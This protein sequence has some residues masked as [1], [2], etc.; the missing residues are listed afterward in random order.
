MAGSDRQWSFRDAEE[1]DDPLVPPVRSEP[2][3]EDPLLSAIGQMANAILSQ[4]DEPRVPAADEPPARDEPPQS[5]PAE[6]PPVEIPIPVPAVPTEPSPP[7][8]WLEAFADRPGAADGAR[9]CG[10]GFARIRGPWGFRVVICR[11]L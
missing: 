10:P 1:P 4:G 6:Q 7:T 5:V 2:A 3:E 11:F 8:P 9:R